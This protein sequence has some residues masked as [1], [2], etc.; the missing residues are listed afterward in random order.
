MTDTREGGAASSNGKAVTGIL[1]GLLGSQATG[2]TES[3]GPEQGAPLPEAGQ[4]GKLCSTQ[5]HKAALGAST[6]RTFKVLG[7]GGAIFGRGWGGSLYLQGPWGQGVPALC[8][9]WGCTPVPQ[10]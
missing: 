2:H 10:R 9:G 1:P 3:Q 4:E 6:M 7:W 8:R 5:F